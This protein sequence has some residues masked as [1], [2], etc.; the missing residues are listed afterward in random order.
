[1]VKLRWEQ[2]FLIPNIIAQTSLAMSHDLA[3]SLQQ[4]KGSSGMLVL[5]HT[6][7]IQQTPITNVFSLMDYL[8]ALFLTTSYSTVSGH[9][10]S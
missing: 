8:L 2:G 1:M 3:I 7:V 9:Q 5:S 4:H 6:I 10:A